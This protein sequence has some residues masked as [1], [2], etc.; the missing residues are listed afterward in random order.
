VSAFAV[1]TTRVALAGK[2][3]ALSSDELDRLLLALAGLEL[4]AAEPLAEQIA[5]LRLAGGTI[6]L[7]PT[8]AGLAALRLALAALGERGEPIPGL[9]RLAAS[10]GDAASGHGIGAA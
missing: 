9:A 7:M 6:D 4:R 10:C 1:Q 8:E 5:A 3:I 2:L